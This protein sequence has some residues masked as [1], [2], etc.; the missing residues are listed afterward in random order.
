M[1]K[2]LLF[3]FAFCLLPFALAKAQ[4]IIPTTAFTRGFLLVNNQAAAQAYLGITGGIIGG[5]TNI[6][7]V[8]TIA[9]LKAAVPSST[10]NV[11]LAV[12]LGYTAAGDNGSGWMYRYDSTS[13]ATADDGAVIQPTSVSG[14]WIILE[15]AGRY[16]AK[17]WGA[18]ITN[19]TLQAAINYAAGQGGGTIT[20]PAGITYLDAVNSPVYLT[21]NVYL[22]G[23]AGASLM[24]GG[25]PSTNYVLINANNTTNAAV[26]NLALLGYPSAPGGNTNNTGYAIS[27]T[28]SSNFNAIFINTS[29]FYTTNYLTTGAVSPV[30]VDSLSLISGI[31]SPVGVVSRALKGTIYADRSSANTIPLWMETVDYSTNGWQLIGGSPIAGVTNGVFYTVNGTTLT[32]NANFA[33]TGTNLSVVPAIL[34]GYFQFYTNS[35]KIITGTGSPE[36][37]QTAPVGSF[38]MSATDGALY[39]KTNGTGN[40][41][42]GVLSTGAITGISG[43]G[44]NGQVA[45]WNSSSSIASSQKFTWT[46][47]SAALALSDPTQTSFTATSDNGTNAAIGILNTTPTLASLAVSNNTTNQ[48]QLQ[49]NAGIAS[50]TMTRNNTNFLTINPTN[51]LIA[52]SAGYTGTGTNVFTDNGSFRS[53]ASAGIVGGSGTAGQLPYWST[54]TTLGDSPLQRVDSTSIGLNSATNI[55][56]TSGANLIYSN[57]SST[58]SFVVKM[59]SNTNSV[60]LDASGINYD[61]AAFASSHKFSVNGTLALTIAGSSIQPSSGIAQNGSTN[62]MWHL[63]YIRSLYATNLVSSRYFFYD[64]S[65]VV[66]ESAGTG[67]PEGV[68]AANVGSEYHRTDG[69][70]STTL[71]VKESGSGNTGWVA[72]GGGGGTV[73]SVGLSAPAEFS[74]SGSPVTTSGTL[75]FS[76]ANQSANLVYAGPTTGA[77][78]APTFRSLVAADLPGGLITGSGT[79]LD[80]ALWN[81][82]NTITGTTAFQY[83]T[84]GGI[85]SFFTTDT[86]LSA[87]TFT[88]SS[89]NIIIGSGQPA[90][91]AYEA[92]VY[93][94]ANPISVVAGGTK[95]TRFE[96]TG[97]VTFPTNIFLGTTILEGQGSNSPEGAITAP[98]GS[99]YRRTNGTANATFYVKESGTGNTGWTAYGNGTVTSVALSAPSE[100]SVSGSP[101]TSSGTLTFTKAN[102]NANVVYAGPSSGSAAAPTFRSLVDDDAPNPFTWRS[103]TIMFDD[104][105]ASHSSGATRAGNLNWTTA[106]S[107]TGATVTQGTP[108]SNRPGVV[109]LGTGTTTT[110]VSLIHL[111]GGQMFY[112]GGVITNEFAVML[113]ALSTAAQEYIYHAGTGD[114]SSN[115]DETDGVYFEYDRLG[116]GVNWIAVTSN[117]S[118]RTRT[119]TGTAVSA[120]AWTD[121]KT[122]VDAAGSN[123]YFYI[124]GTVVATNSANIP[125]TNAR[126]CG[127]AFHLYSSAG[128]TTKTANTDWWY[129]RQDFT[130]SR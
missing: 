71:Y 29:G 58:V 100:F 66:F 8:P 69:G 40:T 4:P 33:Y 127:P 108:T 41:G 56:T 48:A 19:S 44:T 78:A 62:S 117:N 43:S 31:G 37:A 122:V 16:P 119:D 74:V 81:G 96:T 9:A 15:N 126:L 110:G 121:L 72:Y 97:N 68:L 36:G 6:F 38:Y 50:L 17:I 11:K 1:C 3:F 94:A 21:N 70:A 20:L 2:R 5:G 22:S 30:I 85:S 84:G 93:S 49:V 112:G 24:V 109:Q 18:T 113:D 57:G 76:K 111:G 13:A 101:V 82:T 115:T 53:T 75:T 51:F 54:T 28:N 63:G 25:T 27:F 130:S 80:V 91:S 35:V 26:Q 90:A 7:V 39:S 106:V 23:E 12:V 42:W 64:G 103:R 83:Q 45:Y 118:T 95:V 98:V 52:A 116:Q 34:G 102:Q 105:L 88:S 114:S 124:N 59:P 120:A 125:T 32:N 89:G 47:A 129:L 87:A 86:T 67:S 92:F 79:N 107:G 61:S 46:T 14:R 104:F 77:A 10:N 60:N 123:A 73:T 55:L 128:T 99:T 65:P